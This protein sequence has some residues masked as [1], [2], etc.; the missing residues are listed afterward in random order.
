MRRKVQGAA[1]AV[2]MLMAIAPAAQAG[3]R[4]DFTLD[5]GTRTPGAAATFTFDVAY[6]NADDPNG[7]PP[8]ISGATFRLPAGTSIDQ[9][10]AA[11]CTATDEQL[12]AQGRN[13]CPADSRIGGGTLTAITGFGPPA[14]PI[15]G[16]ATVFNGN[17]EI[18]ELVTLPGTNQTAGFDRLKVNGDVLTAHPPSTPGGPPD[19]RTA[20]KDIHLVVDRA[21]FAKAP[22]T[23][24]RGKGWDY[25]ASFEFG[26]GTRGE[27]AKTLAC[28]AT[29]PALALAAQP[30]SI[31]AKRR[32]TV[33]FRVRSTSSD[34]IRG[35]KV[36]FAS[37][38]ARTSARGIATITT[39]VGRA[40]T[41]PVNVSKRGCK[42][43]RGTVAVTR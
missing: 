10:A 17:G 30:A 43:A 22:P 11:K 40:R 4:G 2:L 21:G 1:G 19:G 24:T 18:I 14:D 28:T 9:N 41:L 15:N 6:R 42:T 38:R 31:R 8:P 13:A 23:C 35:A 27:V 37:K 36:R 12:R 34:C 26:D 39:T 20:I 32:T 33:R 16:D 3:E 7:K 29:R 25:S 5:L